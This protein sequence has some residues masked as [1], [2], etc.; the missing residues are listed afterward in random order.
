MR[1][2]PLTARTTWACPHATTAAALHAAYSH[3]S[4]TLDDQAF[5]QA[6]TRLLTTLHATLAHRRPAARP[7]AYLIDSLNGHPRADTAAP[8]AA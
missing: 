3:L 1:H 4:T 7:G 6:A 5:Q 2:L 8:P